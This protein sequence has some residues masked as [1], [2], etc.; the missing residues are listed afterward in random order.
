MNYDI[1]YK[2]GK[3]I[4]NETPSG[5]IV[6]VSTVP[7]YIV[8]DLQGNIVRYNTKTLRGLKKGTYIV[9]KGDLVRKVFWD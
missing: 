1:S 5:G 6:E 4:V 2:N 3:L 9:R 8:Y 7:M